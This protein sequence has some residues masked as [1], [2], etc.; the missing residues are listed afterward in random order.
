MSS[1]I[2]LKRT[3]TPGSIPTANDIAVGEL[4]VNLADGTLYSKRT[5][6]AVIEIAGNLPDEYYL[7]SNQDYGTIISDAE[8]TLD[9]GN[10]DNGS[11]QINLGD[12]NTYAEITQ[13]PESTSSVGKKSQIAIDSNYLYV[14]VATN[15][16]KRIALSSW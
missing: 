5:D 1:V 16:W 8:T 7:S 15:V 2:Q 3:E 13:V 14:C 11:Q 10:L 4:A 6:G 9:L 12:V